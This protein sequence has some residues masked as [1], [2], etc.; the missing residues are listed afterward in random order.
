MLHREDSENLLLSASGS[1]DK[2]N[3]KNMYQKTLRLIQ[4][5]YCRNSKEGN[6]YIFQFRVGNQGRLLGGGGSETENCPVLQSES[7][8]HS[9]P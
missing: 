1:E 8:K 5:S 7:T 3:M 4:I 6:I 2:Y 9:T